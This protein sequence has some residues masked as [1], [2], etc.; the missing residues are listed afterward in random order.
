MIYKE[1]LSSGMLFGCWGVNT[2]QRVD[3]IWRDASIYI[4]LK[5]SQLPLVLI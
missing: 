4:P 3:L 5:I 1:S 2:T